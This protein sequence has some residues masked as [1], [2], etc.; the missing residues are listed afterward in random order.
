[1]WKRIV[2][3]QRWFLWGGLKGASKISSVSWTVVWSIC[4]AGNN[5]M[6]SSRTC[7]VEQLVDKIQFTS[8]H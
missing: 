8:W 6:F 3:I 5:L 2:N 4:F 7:D 1:M